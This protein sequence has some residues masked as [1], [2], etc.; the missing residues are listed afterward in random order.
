MTHD[1]VQCM[2]RQNCCT[3]VAA[4]KF[5]P[6]ILLLQQLKRQIKQSLNLVTLSTSLIFLSKKYFWSNAFIYFNAQYI[7]S[8]LQSKSIAMFSLKILIPCM[9]LNLGLLCLRRIRC[10]IHHAD[11]ASYS[12]IP[13]C[14]YSHECHLLKK[15]PSGLQD[16]SFVQ[17][18]Q[19]TKK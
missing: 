19:F 1:V 11:R 17:K 14:S 13:M 8:Q 2:F 18:Y 10:L 3:T 12:L 6:E 4:I 7:L 5:S 15:Y 9:D 16:F